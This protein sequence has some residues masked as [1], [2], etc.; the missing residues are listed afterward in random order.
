MNVVF[1]VWNR[2]LNFRCNVRGNYSIQRN[3]TDG[4]TF[5]GYMS[6]NLT[7]N[8]VLLQKIFS[9]VNEFHPSCVH[10]KVNPSDKIRYV[11]CMNER[12]IS[13]NFVRTHKFKEMQRSFMH[14]TYH[15]F[16]QDHHFYLPL[17]PTYAMIHMQYC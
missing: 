10:F 16:Q 14:F 13:L 2:K 3:S 9:T 7:R 11:K 8:T 4:V 12:C 6:Q 5:Q 1:R 17:Q 15:I